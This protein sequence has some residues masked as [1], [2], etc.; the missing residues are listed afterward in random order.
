MR[1]LLAAAAAAALLLS[2]CDAEVSPPGESKVDVD[3]PALREL[4][5]KARRGRAAGSCRSSRCP[6]SAAAPTSTSPR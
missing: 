3:T 5:Q 1:H 6:A 4:K 2:G